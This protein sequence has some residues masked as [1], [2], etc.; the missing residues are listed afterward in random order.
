[1]VHPSK[2]DV[3]RG[4]DRLEHCAETHRRK[5]QP[6][7][8]CCGLR[9]LGTSLSDGA[10]CVACLLGA[11]PWNQHLGKAGD[12]SR[13]GGQGRRQEAGSCVCGAGSWAGDP[14]SHPPSLFPGIDVSP[15]SSRSRQSQV[16]PSST[17][18]N[19]PVSLM[20]V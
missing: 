18:H 11:C 6:Q 12:R 15:R 20:K 16:G 19:V 5:S 10:K 8:V 9:S 1:M 3:P 7:V 2:N 4:L 13:G 17:A 14:P